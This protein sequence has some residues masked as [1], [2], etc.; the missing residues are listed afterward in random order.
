MHF[1]LVLD[2]D[3]NLYICNTQDTFSNE[4]ATFYCYIFLPH[5]SILNLDLQLARD[6]IPR[7]IFEHAMSLDTNVTLAACNVKRITDIPTA[8]FTKIMAVHDECLAALEHT[9]VFA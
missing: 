8:T 7:N 6:N 5:T 4:L 1:V 2:T 3:S 9:N